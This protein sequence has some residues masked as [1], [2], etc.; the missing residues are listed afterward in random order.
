[1]S[2]S[3]SRFSPELPEED[4]PHWSG[5]REAG[6]LSG[7][8]FLWAIHRWF[9]RGAVSI[10][11]RPVVLYFVLFKA[12]ARRGS[13]QFLH[14][15]AK[16]YPELWPSPPGLRDQMRHF[17]EFAENVVDKLMAWH[18]ELDQN[19]FFV[20]DPAAHQRLLE[21]PRGQLI[22][23]SHLGNIEYCRGFLHRYR[24]HKINVLLY[25]RHAKNYVEMMRRLNPDSRINVYQ[26][27]EFDIA[28]ILQFK[29]KIDAGEW[30]F[31]AGDRIP[32][33]GVQ[34]TVTVDFLG[35]GTQLP[36][37]P[38]LLA[39]ALECPVKL[40][41]AYK[42]YCGRDKRLHFD[43]IEFAEQIRL[44]AKQRQQ[45][46]QHYAQQYASELENICREAPYQWFNFYEYW[47]S[48]TNGNDEAK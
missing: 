12:Q 19:N 18:L 25:D 38:Y 6:T 35:R 34:R 16:R 23:G 5:I 9:G 15:H 24:S 21:D 47:P 40:M 1:V 45:V 3:D 31:I 32:L 4:E 28:T 13:K 7:L 17:R 33:S 20:R 48:E 29:E 44:P 39:R 42:N 36:I 46:L 30:L 8:R 11:L 37:G 27:D 2:I 14:A 41:F 43:I 10:L 22:I 26:V